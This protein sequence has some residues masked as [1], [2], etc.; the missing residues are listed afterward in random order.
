METER[1]TARPLAEVVREVATAVADSQVEVDRNAVELQREIQR[2]FEDGETDH[3]IEVPWYRFSEVDVDL[4]VALELR[5]RP[6]V[7][8]DGDVRAYEPE[9]AAYPVG[10]RFAEEFDFDLEAASSLS[11]TLVPVPPEGTSGPEGSG[12]GGR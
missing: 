7:D 10:P 3:R 12:D 4:E 9:V 11:V 8:D 2:A 1:W 6:E 5:G